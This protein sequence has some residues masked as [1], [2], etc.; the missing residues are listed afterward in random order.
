M[1]DHLGRDETM[2]TIERTL[3]PGEKI[4]GTEYIKILESVHDAL[5]AAFSQIG[6]RFSFS[7]YD[8]TPAD[9]PDTSEVYG[10]WMRILDLTG[11]CNV[12]CAA[13]DGLVEADSGF[14]VEITARDV[15]CIV[16]A[17]DHLLQ[18]QALLDTAPT[19]SISARPTSAAN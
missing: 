8:Q 3:Q 14:F 13:V 19:G 1:S 9:H 10:C 2:A 7:L 12:M 16:A 4:V 6:A 18:A 17:A 11:Y 5:G 15:E